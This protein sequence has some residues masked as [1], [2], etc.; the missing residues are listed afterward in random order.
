M[1][2]SP[3]QRHRCRFSQ[4][5]TRRSSAAAPNLDP[6]YTNRC[7]TSASVRLTR[8]FWPRGQEMMSDL[9]G[10]VLERPSLRKFL[11]VPVPREAL[12]QALAVLHHAPPN[13]HTNLWLLVFSCCIA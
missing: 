3:R 2:G 11:P 1:A 4:P 8:T 7:V 13:Y 5:F 6:L 10:T 9:Q 12:D